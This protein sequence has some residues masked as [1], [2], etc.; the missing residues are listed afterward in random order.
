M[1]AVLGVIV[2]AVLVDIAILLF[3]EWADRNRR[4][5]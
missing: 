2:V 1:I 3:R 4:L 5:Q